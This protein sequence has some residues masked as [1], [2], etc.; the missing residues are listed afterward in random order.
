MNNDAPIWSQTSS[1]D[2]NDYID[3]AVWRMLE[4][5]PS[6]EKSCASWLHLQCRTIHEVCMGVVVVKSSEQS[7]YEPVA[8]WP[9]R[10]PE[11]KNLTRV[12]ENVLK[13]RK[14]VVVKSAHEQE[15][16]AADSRYQIA[17]P[18]QVSERLHGVAALEITSRPQSE[19]VIA[20]RQLQWGMA[21]LKYQLI[22]QETRQTES[23]QSSLA[24]AF[25]LTAAVLLESTIQ[26]AAMTFATQL[27][28]QIHCDRVSVGF[29][30]GRQIKVLALSHSAQFG[31]QMNLIRSI[32]AAM[33]ECHDQ[34][35]ILLFPRPSQ[36]DNLILRAHEEL[37]VQHHDGAICTIPFLDAKGACYGALTMERATHA[38]FD[39]KTVEYC[40]SVAALAAPILEE[41]RKNDRWLLT[42]AAESFRRQIEHLVGR[43]HVYKKTAA[44]LLLALV[45]F[46]SV[47]TGDYHVSAD[48]A[49]EGAIQRAIVSPYRGYIREADARA[50]DIVD[51][52]QTLCHLDDR[53][54]ILEHLG[55]VSR[56]EQ[57]NRQLQKAMAEGDRAAMKVLQ[58]QVNQADAQ[59]NLLSEQISRAKIAA[60]FHGIIVK[61]D[62][63]QSLGA[64]VERGDILFE[65]APLDAYRVILE[66]DEREVRSVQVGQKGKLLLNA[67]PGEPFPFSIEKITPVSTAKEGR[68]CFRVEAK[69]EDISDQLRPGMEGFGRIFIDRRKLIWIWT[70][71]IIDWMKIWIWSWRP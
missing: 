18:I 23:D 35:A 56:K 16:N 53:D 49:I 29:L 9:Q 30:K 45:V 50:G 31:K 69:L 33:D 17:Y 14:G 5:A 68:N 41:K 21:W 27:A 54:M 42:K 47:K 4:D 24:S 58:E 57:N 7:M 11:C 48:A 52:G 59:I 37:A 44:L 46:F 25:N 2:A 66:V 3:P 63:S 8:F 67:L 10:M 62:L 38:P 43:G 28:A 55:W 64:P 12:T 51:A 60:P 6:L 13:E 36:E 65:M 40:E 26:A 34:K 19:I 70:H 22:R 39:G 20:M 61:G 71:D 15:S 32:G 1:A